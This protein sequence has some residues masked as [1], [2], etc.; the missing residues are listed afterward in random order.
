MLDYLWR[1]YQELDG[2]FCVSMISVVS[3][4]KNLAD[5]NFRNEHL[6][7]DFAVVILLIACWEPVFIVALDIANGS[8]L[9][10]LDCFRNLLLDNRINL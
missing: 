6:R 2:C 1:L 3:M 7:F 4:Y 8:A 10:G 5:P 9:R